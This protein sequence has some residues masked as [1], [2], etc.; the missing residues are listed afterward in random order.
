MYDG[1]SNGIELYISSN[2]E[3]T[4]DYYEFFY[5]SPTGRGDDI[6]INERTARYFGTGAVTSTYRNLA[7]I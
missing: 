1:N 7:V 3:A 2:G 6:P 4:S 5:F